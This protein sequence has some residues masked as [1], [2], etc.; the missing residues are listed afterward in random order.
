MHDAS[1]QYVNLDISFVFFQIP[2]GAVAAGEKQLVTLALN[3]DLSDFPAMENRQ[4]LISPVVYC[5]PHGVT[6]HKPCTLSFKHCAFD[7]RMV[8]VCEWGY[9]KYCT[10]ML[11]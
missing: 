1:T 4:A 9:I 10:S 8:K 11:L 5:G 6:F 3:W 7:P 2:P